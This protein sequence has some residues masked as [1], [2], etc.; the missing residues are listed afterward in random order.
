[1]SVG[2]IK[3]CKGS[4]STDFVDVKDVK[5]RLLDGAFDRTCKAGEDLAG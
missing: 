4:V 1:M 3:A 2:L 5:L